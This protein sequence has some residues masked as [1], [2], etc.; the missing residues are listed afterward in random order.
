MTAAPTEFAA[1]K[2]QILASLDAYQ[3]ALEQDGLSTPQMIKPELGPLDDPSHL[4]SWQLT[5]ARDTLLGSL[6]QMQALVAH[7]GERLLKLSFS[8]HTSAALSLVVE[9]RVADALVAAG[10]DGMSLADL[11]RAVGVAQLPLVTAMRLLANDHVF[12][13][14]SEDRWANNR[15]SLLLVDRSHV[16]HYIRHQTWFSLRHSAYISDVWRDPRKSAST[17]PAD[18]AAA[19]A[20]DFHGNG[21]ET[22][23]DMLKAAPGGRLESFGRAMGAVAQFSLP[24]VLQDY[25]WKESVPAGGTIVDVGGGEGHVLLPLLKLNDSWNGVIQDRPEVLPNAKANMQQ[26]LGTGADRVSYVEID[27]LSE[28]SGVPHWSVTNSERGCRG[29]TC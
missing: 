27:F 26:Q 7:P 8:H 24:G 25:P 11:G 3:S 17:A 4:P 10:P 20:Y 9:S 21:Y 23:W 16:W 14:V 6:H 1:L 13:Q 22:T 5:N 18:T 29:S 12:T 28:S 15:A 2:Q 19:V